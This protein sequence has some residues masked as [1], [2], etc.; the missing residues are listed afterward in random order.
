M[1]ERQI[2]GMVEGSMGAG[3]SMM[4]EEDSLEIE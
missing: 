1:A 3:G 4:P 2:A